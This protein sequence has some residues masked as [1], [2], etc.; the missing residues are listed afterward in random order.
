MKYLVYY[1]SDYGYF[2]SVEDC[3]LLA[4]KKKVNKYVKNLKSH[5]GNG[6]Q[7]LIVAKLSSVLINYKRPELKL[8]STEKT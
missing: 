5:L 2:H 3:K 4:N 1:K 8:T 6:I 7:T